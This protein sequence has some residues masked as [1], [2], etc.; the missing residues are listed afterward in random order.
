MT[1]TH[2]CVSPH[3]P[4]FIPRFTFAAGEG[5]KGFCPSWLGHELGFLIGNRDLNAVGA[6]ASG[7]KRAGGNS[8]DMCHS[9]A[10]RRTAAHAPVLWLPENLGRLNRELVHE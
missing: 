8:R 5:R 4:A 1:H 3:N 10:T 2:R 7:G 6:N 9:T